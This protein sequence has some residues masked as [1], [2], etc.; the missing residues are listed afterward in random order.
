MAALLALRK[1]VQQ[2]IATLPP[3]VLFKHTANNIT[4]FDGFPK[5]IFHFLV[6][7]RLQPPDLDVKVLTNLQSLMKLDKEQA[8]RVI[9][10]LAEDAKAIKK[11][12]ESEMIKRYGFKWDV[13]IGF[14]GAPSMV[15]VFL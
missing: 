4:I 14:H 1:F 12:I 10:S 5:S 9:T 2:D 7:P 11:D 8:K 3:S 13:W 6:L 15:C